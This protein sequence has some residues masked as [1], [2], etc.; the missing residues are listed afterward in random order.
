M[1]GPSHSHQAVKIVSARNL[2]FASRF[3]ENEMGIAT[4][5]RGRKKA[6]SRFTVRDGLLILAVVTATMLAIVLLWI[7]G[8]FDFDID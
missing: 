6:V 1:G 2:T 3:C 7:L 8:F 4:D 5:S